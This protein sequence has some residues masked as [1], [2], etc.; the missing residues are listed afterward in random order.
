VS[1]AKK[2]PKDV[3][4]NLLKLCATGRAAAQRRDAAAAE[5]AFV[6]AWALIPDSKAE[7]DFYPQS[8]ARGLVEHFSSM[9]Q[10]EK[11]KAWLITT[12]AM[13][14]SDPATDASLGMLE[15]KVRFEAGELDEA[16]EIFSDLHRKH[17]KRPFAGADPK[18]LRLV[19]R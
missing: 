4:T 11:A 12:R 19:T 5:R 14:G 8:L 18:Y 17:G 1:G 2:L 6:E 7:W 9:G 13:Y 3:E 10:H 15:G 16:R